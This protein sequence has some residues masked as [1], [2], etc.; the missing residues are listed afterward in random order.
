MGGEVYV[1]FDPATC[2]I[3]TPKRNAETWFLCGMG[4][5]AVSGES[6]KAMLARARR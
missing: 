2:G 3:A 6:D 4:D 5:R 1:R